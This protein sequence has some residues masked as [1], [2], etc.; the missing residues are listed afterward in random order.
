VDTWLEGIGP[1]TRISSQP[2]N[3]LVTGSRDQMLSARSAGHSDRKLRLG[4]LFGNLE[5]LCPLPR[6]M[7][8][9]I[10]KEATILFL[11]TSSRIIL[12]RQS[13]PS[14]PTWVSDPVPFATT[15]ASLIE[16]WYEPNIGKTASDGKILIS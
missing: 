4:I 6:W 9:Y 14:D 13:L 2:L 12:V 3:R 1:S 16:D 10:T 5:S 11:T 8:D 7:R 15:W